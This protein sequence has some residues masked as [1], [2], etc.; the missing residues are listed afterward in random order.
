MKLNFN[1]IVVPMKIWY[2]LRVVSD[3]MRSKHTKKNVTTFDSKTLG[4]TGSEIGPGD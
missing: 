1:Y 2:M 4:F 3:Q